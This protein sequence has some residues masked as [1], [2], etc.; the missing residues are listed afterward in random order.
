MRNAASVETASVRFVN[1]REVERTSLDSADGEGNR[2]AREGSTSAATALHESI[3]G[4][5]DL[6]GFDINSIHTT[7]IKSG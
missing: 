3:I 7:K 5:T 2:S 6:N 4:A 1:V